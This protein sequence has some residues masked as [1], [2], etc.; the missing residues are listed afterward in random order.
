MKAWVQEEVNQQE[1][2]KSGLPDRK[3]HVLARPR[4][5]PLP[6]QQKE[7]RWHYLSQEAVGRLVWQL[8]DNSVWGTGVV[9]SPEQVRYNTSM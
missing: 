6:D 7:G 3:S 8:G 4:S 5:Q 9:G 1:R 2:M